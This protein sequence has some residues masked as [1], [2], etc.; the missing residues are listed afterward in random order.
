M[1]V[2]KN[3]LMTGNKNILLCLL[4]VLSSIEIHIQETI[5]M[6][7]NSLRSFFFLN[8]VTDDTAEERFF[9]GKYLVNLVS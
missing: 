1:T 7:K 5:N 6:C 4:Y 2:N 8:L 9:D 3:I